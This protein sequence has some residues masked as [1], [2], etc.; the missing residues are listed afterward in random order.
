MIRTGVNVGYSDEFRDRE[1]NTPL[2]ESIA[3]LPA[4][5]GKPGEVAAAAAGG[6]GERRRG[7]V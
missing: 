4:K 6:A 2:L 5:G 7:E 3:K 1:T